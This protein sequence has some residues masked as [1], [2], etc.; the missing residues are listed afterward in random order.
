MDDINEEF[1]IP[2][3]NRAGAAEDRAVLEQ[4]ISGFLGYS[5]DLDNVKD[6]LP[7]HLMEMPE[8]SPLEEARLRVMAA[9]MTR[10][11][12]SSRGESSGISIK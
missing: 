11:R 1:S 4:A 3:A 9:A 6:N 5:I 8:L 2:P 12:A 10:R 7:P